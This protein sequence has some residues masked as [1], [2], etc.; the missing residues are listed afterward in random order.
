MR[1]DPSAPS[2][3][4]ATVAPASSLRRPKVLLVTHHLGGG[5]ERH[6]QELGR[7]AEAFFLRLAPGGDEVEL[8]VTGHPE[9]PGLTLPG[10]RSPR[11]PGC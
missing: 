4:A 2:R 10:T 5:T 9:H 8:S 1:R 7:D 3:F 6:V 11:S